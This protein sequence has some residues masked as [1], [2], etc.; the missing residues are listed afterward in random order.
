MIYFLQYSP[1]IPQH[2]V[3]FLKRLQ[4]LLY[5]WDTE[6]GDWIRLNM[7]KVTSLKKGDTWFQGALYQLS[8]YNCFQMACNE[9]LVNTRRAKKSY[10]VVKGSRRHADKVQWREKGN[11]SIARI[12]LCKTEA[13]QH[14]CQSKAFNWIWKKGSW[15]EFQNIPSIGHLT[16]VI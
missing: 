15:I 9:K 8:L 1:T 11:D 16:N 13:G 3:F 7:L 6:T 2:I 14:R 5:S 4:T 10:H 12:S